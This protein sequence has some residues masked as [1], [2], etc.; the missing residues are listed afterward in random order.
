MKMGLDFKFLLFRYDSDS[1][2][3]TDYNYITCEYKIYQIFI[4]ILKQLNR[5]K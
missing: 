1:M 3:W 2:G 5:I 4:D